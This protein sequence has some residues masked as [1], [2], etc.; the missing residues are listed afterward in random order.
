VDLSVGSPLAVAAGL[1]LLL[2]GAAGATVV[3]RGFEAQ[4]EA[5]RVPVRLIPFGV[6]IGGGASLVRGWDLGAG[7]LVGALLVPLVAAAG[8]MIEV[9]RRRRGGD[10]DGRSGT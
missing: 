3:A 10:R 1:V 9:R 7:A 5:W 4:G 2:L 6:L 8:R